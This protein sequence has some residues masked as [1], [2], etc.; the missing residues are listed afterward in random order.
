MNRADLMSLLPEMI[1]S[2]AGIVILL[3]D[4]IAPKLRRAFTALAIL[5]VAGTAW[6][7]WVAWSQ[8]PGDSMLT[9]G[10]LLET[11][12]VTYS[13]S[14]VILL[15]TGLCLLAS[16]GYL[17]REGILSGE[18]HALLLWCATGLLLMLRGTELLTIFLSLELFSFCLYSLAVYHR[19]LAIASEAALK[20]FLMGAFVSSFVLYGLALVYG[21]T[22]TTRLAEVGARLAVGGA[23]PVG[24]SL[25]LLLLVAGF[26]FKM[27][28]VPF[29]A[30]SPDTY[31][32]APSPFVAFLSVAPKVAS[33]LVLFRLLDAVV[34]GGVPAAIHK[35]SVVV[36]ALAV[37]SMLV[38]N[39]LALA[40][41]DIKRM[42]AYSGI[43]HMGYLLL[44][45]VVLDRGS[46][47][48]VIVYLLAYVLMNAGAFT[49]VAMLYS[50]P[51]EQ[52]LISDLSGYGYRYPLLGACLGICMLSLAGIPPTVG[53]LG[54]Y[55][56]F[57]NAVGDGLVGLAVL[58]V[59]A[60]LIGVFYYLRVIF[61]LYMK[62]EERQPEG[63]LL[64]IWGRT[65]AV[66][67]ALGT[68]AL[69]IWPTGLVQWL[70]EATTAK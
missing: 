53:F 6:G 46:L 39:L 63:L 8:F 11:S 26:A 12:G 69:G 65:A 30:W 10:G 70:L 48:P 49:V 13:L 29:H 40:Q 66:V 33:A 61:V 52:H 51:G 17:R 35:W 68:L 38:G 9:W 2:G 43:A 50:R 67:A 60:S 34:Q 21:A 58:G 4:A 7:A 15:A 23:I 3:L 45:L 27:S 32:G 41:R 5:A 25:G 37:M 56:V 59:L 22:G 55:L 24:A 42:L 54:K 36:A 62:A 31:Q 14:L 16:Q 18:Y 20:Y 57:L 47:M 64:D 28:I 44:A 1:L 19:R